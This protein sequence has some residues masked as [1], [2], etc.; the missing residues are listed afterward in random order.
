MKKV[1]LVRLMIGLGL[2]IAFNT[3]A[4]QLK[5]GDHVIHS[6]ISYQNLNRLKIQNGVIES[7]AGMES[8]FFLEK[9]DKTGEVYIRPTSDN[10]Y[11]PISL[12]VT[13]STGRTQD[14]LLEVVDG[15]P[16][17]IE[18]IDE[19]SKKLTDVD[20]SLTP[21]EGE[22]TGENDYEEIICRVMKKLINIP[23]RYPTIRVNV[24]DRNFAHIKAT[25][26]EAYEI[27]GFV[28]LKYKITSDRELS[29]PSRLDERMFTRKGDICL[30][31]SKY[32][33]TKDSVAT[34]YVLRR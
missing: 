32:E 23:E 10:G 30:S 34:L 6:Q 24:S 20:K 22:D 33:I 4:V 21:A 8:A 14:L 1:K 27:D 2:G 18:L 13:T 11:T 31:L 17:T 9:N 15:E 12:S 25:L 29:K 26:A 19:D 28:A 5:M 7:I 16:N 3:E